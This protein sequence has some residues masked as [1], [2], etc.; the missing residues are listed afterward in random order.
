MKKILFVAALAASTSAFATDSGLYGA[1]DIGQ[2]Q[3]SSISQGGASVSFANTTPFRLGVGYQLNK[4]FGVEGS[5]VDFGKS[6]MTASALGVGLNAGTMK[7]SGFGI[8]AIGS[9]PVS[10][11]VELFGKIGYNSIKV[12][13]S[14]SAPFAAL[15]ALASSYTNNKASFGLGAKFNLSKEL[16]LR[17]QYEDFGSMKANATGASTKATMFSLGAT[18]AF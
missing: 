10:D 5:Y 11:A 7:A 16:A 12:T 9:L 3:L 14:P 17:A 15:G 8:A 18:Y 13:T 1:F 2:G 4:N 6:D